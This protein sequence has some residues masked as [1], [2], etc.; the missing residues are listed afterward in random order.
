M[1]IQ[2]NACLKDIIILQS[3]RLY[4]ELLLKKDDHKNLLEV[5]RRNYENGSDY[6]KSLYG[7]HPDSVDFDHSRYYV[8]AK[9]E[10]NHWL[11]EDMETKS[12]NKLYYAVKLKSTDQQKPDEIIGTVEIYGNQRCLEFGLFIDQRYSHQKYGTEALKRAIEF[13]KQN[14]SVKKIKWECNADNVGSVGVATKCG[15]I[16]DSDWFIYEGRKAS[17]FYL[18]L[19]PKQGQNN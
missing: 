10:R 8:N 6:P 11:A 16:H 12:F 5:F 1:S 19:E 18:S 17:T 13:V 15:F 7:D 14:T 3:E 9:F 2:L 4:L